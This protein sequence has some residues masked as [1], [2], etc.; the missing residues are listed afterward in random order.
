MWSKICGMSECCLRL[1]EETQSFGVQ[2]SVLRTYGLLKELKACKKQ[3]VF[4]KQLQKDVRIPFL[5]HY[6]SRTTTV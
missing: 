1:L 2:Y 6:D 4:R 3:R 5:A